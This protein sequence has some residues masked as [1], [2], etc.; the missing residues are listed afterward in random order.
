MPVQVDGDHIGDEV[1][2][3]FGVEPRALNVVVVALPAAALPGDSALA[4]PVPADS[5]P[6][7]VSVRSVPVIAAPPSQSHG[8]VDHLVPFAEREPD[9]LLPRPA[10][11][12]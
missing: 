1:E 6:S 9:E 4:D 5:A 12:S 7:S 2:A 10:G 3:V 11:S 8:F